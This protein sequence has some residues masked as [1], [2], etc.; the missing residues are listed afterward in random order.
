MSKVKIAELRKARAERV[1]QA[2]AI[3]DRAEREKRELSPEE[4][5]Q[6]DALMSEVDS[7][8][9]RIER[10]EQLLELETEIITEDVTSSDGERA[11]S[12]EDEDR[13]EERRVGNAWISW[14]G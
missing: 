2:R 8:R 3:L 11:Q 6:F 12:E 13:S 9:Q 14:R 1:A 4:Q 7:L 10:L 5:A